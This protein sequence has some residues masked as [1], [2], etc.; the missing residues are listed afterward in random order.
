MFKVLSASFQILDLLLALLAAL[1][2]RDG[3]S[4]TDLAQRPPGSEAGGSEHY[5]SF[6]DTLFCVLASCTKSSASDP[7]RLVDGDLKQS[8][9]T[10]K[11]R[12]QV[13]P[14]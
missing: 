4:L 1:I 9:L 5:T 3:A 8:G 2:S 13:F 7:L 11:D 12:A 14:A 6:V 10:K